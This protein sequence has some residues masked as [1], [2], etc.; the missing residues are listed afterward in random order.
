[1]QSVFFNRQLSKGKEAEMR[2]RIRAGL[3]VGVLAAF[4]IVSMMTLGTGVGN[5]T[6]NLIEQ[7]QKEYKPPV[8]LLPA[9]VSVKPGFE[10][11]EGSVIGNVQMA[12]GEVYVIHKGSSAAYLLKEYLP[13]FVADTLVSGDRS[14]VNVKMNDKSVFALA[15]NSKLVI[16]KSIYDPSK[17]ERSSLLTL[18]FGKARLIV[19]KLR[20]NSQYE[21]RSPTAV[22]GVRGSDFGLSV[23]PEEKKSSALNN[24]LFSF[25]LVRKAYAQPALGPLVTIVVTGPETTL[26]FTGAAGPTQTVGPA[27]ASAAA[28]GAS[29]TAPVAVGG[30]AATGAL[31]AVG[32]G[33]ASL[34]MPPG[35]K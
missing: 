14:R 10:P 5:T 32:P 22:C 21:V 29:A 12:Q 8:P 7:F 33:L 35:Y 19:S 30:A 27:S 4:F 28:T 2:F 17:D 26:G 25:F 3:G 18:L 6:E 31:N 11:G 20:G 9:D 24:R 13:L 16:D 15:P 34:S 1:L 23:G